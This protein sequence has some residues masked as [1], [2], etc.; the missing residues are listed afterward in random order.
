MSFFLSKNIN[1]GYFF[2]LIGYFVHFYWKR[3][4][5]LQYDVD[6]CQGYR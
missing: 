4:M 5:K 2:I 1:I 3:T 6:D